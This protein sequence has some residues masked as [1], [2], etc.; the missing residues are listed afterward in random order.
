MSPVKA[1]AAAGRLSIVVLDVWWS[2]V[3]GRGESVLRYSGRPRR[4]A[5]KIAAIEAARAAFRAGVPIEVTEQIVIRRIRRGPRMPDGQR[6][7]FVAWSL[8]NPW[9]SRRVRLERMLLRAQARIT[10]RSSGITSA[11]HQPRSSIKKEAVPMANTTAES[12]APVSPAPGISEEFKRGARAAAES[13][14]AYFQDENQ[15][16]IY[17]V[18]NDELDEFEKGAVDDALRDEAAQIERDASFRAQI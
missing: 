16:A 13:M 14:K 15:Y 11:R 3:Q 2:I 12:T 1:P 9:A 8:G 4:V 10:R 17:D 6:H 18:S 5:I 7:V